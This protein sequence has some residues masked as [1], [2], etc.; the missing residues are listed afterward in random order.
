MPKVSVVMPAYNAE[1][2]INEAI[3]S[4][5]NQTFKDFEF[6]II[7]DGSTDRTE[8][9]ILSYNDSRI[10]YLKNKENLKIVETL[11]RGLD[12][13]KG[14]YIA[15][16]DADDIAVNTRIEK[17]VAVMDADTSIGVLGTGT[18]VFGETVKTKE[19]HS[20]LNP[21]RLKADLLFST[22]ICHPS[23]MIRK[24]VLDNYNIRY[25]AEYVG[26]EDYELWWQI[27]SVSKI[28]TIPD[29][30]HCYRIHANQVTQVK[31]EQY[32][33][34]LMKMI[35][36]RLY[37]LKLSL[38]SYEKEIFLIYC[39]G[40]FAK[41]DREKM[42]VYIDIIIKILEN[43]QRNPFFEQKELKN[44][45]ALSVTFANNNSEMTDREKKDLYQ[46]AV[47]KHVYPFSMRLK[48]FAHKFLKK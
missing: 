10:V 21:D 47:H 28:M 19:T 46:Y 34:L 6:I 48:L 43:N 8:E 45:V 7:N 20:T 2:Y 12:R 11:N 35:E 32:K 9:I 24:K 39:L 5:L 16:M 41:F 17:Q 25:K 27:A 40:D 30:L 37:K 3:Q 33:N 18:R 1:K 44:V 29:I 42:H 15:R 26:A 23:V 36:L 38:T 22:C 31:D 14:E 4:I 13:A